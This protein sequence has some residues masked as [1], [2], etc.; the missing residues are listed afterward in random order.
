ML[1]T[2]LLYLSRAKWARAI[3]THFF[4][5]RRMARRFVAGETLAEAVAATRELNRK[6][7]TVSLDLLG[8]NVFNEADAL[9]AA[10]GYFKLLEAIQEHQLN[11]DVSVKLTQLGLDIGNELVLKNMRNLLDKA[12]AIGTGITIDMEGSEYTQRTLDIFHQLHQEYDNLGTVIQSY[13]YRSEADMQKLGSE[14]AQIRLCK[15]AYK[16]PADIAFPQKSDV[17]ANYIKVMNAFMSSENRAQGAYLKIAT[18]DPKMIQAALDLIKK[19]NIPTDQFEFQML[20]GIRTGTQE[21]LTKQGYRVR[22]YVPYGTQ[23]YP[24]FMRRLAERPAN[25]WFFFKNFFTR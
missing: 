4:V 18:H 15:G 9:R 12:R 22:I 20:Y 2:I 10:E 6:G 5:T 11:S 13:L 24:Y 1:R 25:L 14:G 16:E 23:W 8:E 17:D 19:E 21:E 3:V 7:M